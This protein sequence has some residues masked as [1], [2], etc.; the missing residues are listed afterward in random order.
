[1]MAELSGIRAKQCMEKARG[2]VAAMIGAK[3]SGMYNS[4]EIVEDYFTQV[5][6]KT[7]YVILTVPELSGTGFLFHSYIHD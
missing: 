1:M 5:P 4:D 6:F 2:H 7:C 3:D